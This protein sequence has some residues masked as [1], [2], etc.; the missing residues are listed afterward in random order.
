MKVEPRFGPVLYFVDDCFNGKN[1]ERLGLK[2][3]C[4]LK[5]SLCHNGD[6]H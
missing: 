6:I 5:N 3:E 4:S 2:L 1:F